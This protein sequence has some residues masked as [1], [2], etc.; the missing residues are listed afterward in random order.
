MP[1]PARWAG[2]PCA[3]HGTQR[4]FAQ[5]MRSGSATQKSA[6]C[7]RVPG[8]GGRTAGDAVPSA[9]AA[10][11]GTGQCRSPIPRSAAERCDGNRR[12]A[13]STRAADSVRASPGPRAGRP[14]GSH[15][16][17]SML[18]RVEHGM[19]RRGAP[20]GAARRAVRAARPSRASAPP[21][22]ARP[23]RSRK[24][25]C[26]AWRAAPRRKQHGASARVQPTRRAARTFVRSPSRLPSAASTSASR[27]RS[28]SICTRS[29]IADGK[30][31]R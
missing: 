8:M 16:V 14:R 4:A 20:R 6:A 12:W 19:L 21:A 31:R 17:R 30:G 13:C 1:Q 23:E 26:H 3:T 27:R 5:W 25:H 22:R 2:L 10:P 29:A 11:H 15:V 9:A 28:T 24:R 7:E 18:A